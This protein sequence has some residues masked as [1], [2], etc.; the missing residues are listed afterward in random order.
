MSRFRIINAKGRWEERRFKFRL[1][2]PPAAFQTKAFSH[3]LRK[4]I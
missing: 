1:A 4:H 3:L 2:V